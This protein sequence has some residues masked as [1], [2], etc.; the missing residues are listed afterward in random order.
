MLLWEIKKIIKRREFIF[1]ALLMLFTVFVDFLVNCYN[2]FGSNMSVLYPAYIMTA[3]DNI[4][5][6]PLRVIFTTALPLLSAIIASDTYLSDKNQQ[7]NTYIITRINKRHY[8]KTQAAAVFLVP[9]F[10]TISVLLLNLLLCIIAFPLYGYELHGI[11]I[12]LDLVRVNNDNLFY[13]LS[14]YHPYINLIFF[15]VMR[16]ILAGVF[17]LLAYGVSFI[18]RI[19]KYVVYVS[20]LII[21]A[22]IELLESMAEQMLFRIGK[23]ESPI[24]FLLYSG[25]FNMNPVGNIFSYL[26]DILLYTLA[27][28]ILIYIGIRKEE[29]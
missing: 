22:V 8:I 29:V 10:L 2:Y 14:I 24:R 4:S 23:E 13:E 1:A 6:E 15:I 18:S 9:F 3:L 25:I 17:A 26:K 11:L 27:A 12:P 16:G 19:N 7:I 5:R 20:S 28:I 21:F